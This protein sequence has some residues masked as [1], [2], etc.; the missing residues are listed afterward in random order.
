ML[1]KPPTITRWPAIRPRTRP[2]RFA[3]NPYRWSTSK[4]PIRINRNNRQMPDIASHV[5]TTGMQCTSYPLRASSSA[6]GPPLVRKHKV[7]RTDEGNFPTKRVVMISVPPRSA[8][9]K[10]CN[11]L[12]TLAS[13]LLVPHLEA[14]QRPQPVGMVASTTHVLLLDLV[15]NV[16]IEQAFSIQSLRIEVVSNQIAQVTS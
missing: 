16:P 15:H 5:R 11:T 12:S 13:I 2:R 1:R 6:M 3:R 4:H 10:I 7:L 9:P 14:H 8:D